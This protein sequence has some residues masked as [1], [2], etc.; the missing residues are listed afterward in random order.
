[1]NLSI[2]FP[3][4]VTMNSSNNQYPDPLQFITRRAGR[5]GG[6]RAFAGGWQNGA[7]L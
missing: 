5:A 1:M 4:S 7:A 6:A 2:A 3:L